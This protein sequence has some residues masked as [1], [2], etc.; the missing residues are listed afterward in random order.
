MVVLILVLDMLKVGPLETS[1]RDNLN[2][3]SSVCFA[4][5]VPVPLQRLQLGSR[6]VAGLCATSEL[7]TS[8]TEV[9]VEDAF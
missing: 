3:V 7:L 1:K 2:I 6:Q 8:E 4:L 5:S 9:A